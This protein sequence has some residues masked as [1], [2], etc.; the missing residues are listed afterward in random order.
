MTSPL[1]KKKTETKKVVVAKK[2]KAKVKAKLAATAPASSTNKVQ[3]LFA[4]LSYL[5][6]IV[7]CS[8]PAFSSKII[9]SKLITLRS[10]KPYYS[11]VCYY[12]CFYVGFTP[13]Q[14]KRRVVYKCGICGTQ[15]SNED[16][17]RPQDAIQYHIMRDHL[18]YKPY[19]CPVCKYSS[20][21]IGN[22]RPHIRSMHARQHNLLPFLRKVI[23]SSLFRLAN[24]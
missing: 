7:T 12:Y 11:P 19:G 3:S 13:F 10:Y 9:V 17:R 15:R 1:K 22:I 20:V 2:T 24:P 14:S 4:A 21:S 6:R 18:S 16:L 8:F 5:P 23:A